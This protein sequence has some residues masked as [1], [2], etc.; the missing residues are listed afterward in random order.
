MTDT[1]SPETRSRIMSRIRSKDT[2]P[3][4]VVRSI[5]S[6]AGWRY[7]LHRRDLPGTPDVVIPSVKA[8]VD[9]R[10]C[11]FHACRCRKGKVPATNTQFWADKF[12]R[13]VE[14]DRR[15]VRALRRLG[16]HVVVV[17]ECQTKDADGLAKTLLRRIIPNRA[18]KR[19]TLQ[20]QMLRDTHAT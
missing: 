5:L 10:G 16:W 19:R 7:R 15:S 3:E 8:V 2:T 20:L 1:V 18:D 14:R 4:M 6:R 11:Y 12:R 17:W 9:V 13:N